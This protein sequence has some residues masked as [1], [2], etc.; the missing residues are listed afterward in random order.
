MSNYQ[1]ADWHFDHKLKVLNDFFIYLIPIGRKLESPFQHF[2]DR[3]SHLK[4]IVLSN[5]N[6]KNLKN[7]E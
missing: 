3:A 6:K 2:D 4:N 5:K 7:I 1:N